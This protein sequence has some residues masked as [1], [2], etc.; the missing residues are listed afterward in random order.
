MWSGVIYRR[1][2]AITSLDADPLSSS[3]HAPAQIEDL[4]N[5]QQQMPPAD[6]YKQ[7]QAQQPVPAPAATPAAVG[8]DDDVAEGDDNEAGIEQKDIDLVME[9]AHVPRAK[10][11]QA[12]KKNNND[13]VNAIMD[14]TM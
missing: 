5:Q 9:Q 10:A 1:G 7:M 8:G 3:F 14:L 6:A 4:S 13:I 11:V 2:T 12:L